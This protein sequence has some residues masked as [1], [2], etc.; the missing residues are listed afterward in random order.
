MV[1]LG[2]DRSP[3]G[4]HRYD[5]DG[6]GEITFREL[7]KMLRHNPELSKPAAAPKKKVEAKVDIVDL[8]VLRQG[9]WKSMLSSKGHWQNEVPTNMRVRDSGRANPTIGFSVMR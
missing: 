4:L 7:H 5:A 1:N 8:A 3:C 2:H 9:T 6:S